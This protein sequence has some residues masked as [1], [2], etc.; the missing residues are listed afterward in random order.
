MLYAECHCAECR[1]LFVVMLNVIMVRAIMLRVVMLNVIVLSVVAPF[2]TLLCLASSLS[3]RRI[4]FQSNSLSEY[5]STED[6]H[7]DF[8]HT[9]KH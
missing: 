9:G 1:N 4:D 2:T 7:V 3:S 6:P 5:F 8:R